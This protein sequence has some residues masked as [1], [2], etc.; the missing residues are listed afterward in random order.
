MTSEQQMAANQRNALRSTG[1][2]SGEE[3]AVVAMNAMKHG[4]VS[5]QVLIPGEDEEELLAF[6]RRLC[7]QLAP[8]GELELLL[9]DRVIS[10]AWRLRRAL[11]VSA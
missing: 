5:Q 8:V 1:P 11:S 7:V 10:S 2:K 4:L 3:K 6:G 9:V